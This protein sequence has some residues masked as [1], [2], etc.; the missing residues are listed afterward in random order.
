MLHNFGA[1]L[2]CYLLQSGIVP[3]ILTATQLKEIILNGLDIFRSYSFPL[4]LNDLNNRNISQFL[5]LLHSE[6]SERQR[7]F[8]VFIPFLFNNRRYNLLKLTPFA[9]IANTIG[10]KNKKTVL[11]AGVELPKY[12]AIGIEDH[13]EI[14]SL[15]KCSPTV[16]S[17]RILW[18]RKSISI[19]KC[20]IDIIKNETS[21]ALE[22]CE[23]K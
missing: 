19:R 8:H 18:L 6:T 1:Y 15:E 9:F 21:K 3:Q 14:N 10:Q 20:S 12:I 23:Y 7:Y 11:V 5:S 2:S 16:N 13:V 4:S 17:S 22:D